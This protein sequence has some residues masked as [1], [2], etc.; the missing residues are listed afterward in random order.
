MS[1]KI[2]FSLSVISLAVLGFSVSSFADGQICINDHNNFYRLNYTT[3]PPGTVIS[4]SANNQELTANAGDTV[5]TWA[6]LAIG[7]IPGGMGQNQFLDI[8]ANGVQLKTLPQGQS[9][10]GSGPTPKP[11]APTAFSFIAGDSSVIPDPNH[12]GM[13]QATIAWGEWSKP[14]A[15][16]VEVYVDGALVQ[17]QTDINGG[18]ENKTTINN[19]APGTHKVDL[20]AIND[21]GST[22][23]NTTVQSSQPHTKTFHANPCLQVA[24]TVN[25]YEPVFKVTNVCNTDVG[26]DPESRFLFNS[27]KDGA[28]AKAFGQDTSF[29]YRSKIGD[30]YPSKMGLTM[31]D[32]TQ[33]GE[34]K[35]KNQEFAYMQ[36]DQANKILHANDSLSF[37]FWGFSKSKIAPAANLLDA[38]TGYDQLNNPDILSA[39][40]HNNGQPTKLTT[41]QTMQAYMETQTGLQIYTFAMPWNQD[42]LIAT[43]PLAEKGPYKAQPWDFKSKSGQWY[44]APAQ[45]VSTAE[46]VDVSYA[47]HDTSSSINVST[48]YT[49]ND[50]SDLSNVQ[51]G[52][53]MSAGGIGEQQTASHDL[54]LNEKFSLSNLLDNRNFKITS[55][56]GE[57][58]LYPRTGDHNFY[59][60]LAQATPAIKKGNEIDV[61]TGAGSSQNVN[62]NYTCQTHIA[63]KTTVNIRTPFGYKSKTPIQITIADQSHHTKPIVLNETPNSHETSATVY[64]RDRDTYS[65]TTADLDVK[66]LFNH[67]VVY[68]AI[69]QP[70]NYVASQGGA[71]NI[72]YKR[73]VPTFTPF[74]DITLGLGA[75][76]KKTALPK[77]L[78]TITAAFLVSNGGSC[79][80]AWGGYIGE[81]YNEGDY[82]KS[83]QSFGKKGGHLYIS[84]GGESGVPISQAC[85][86]AGDLASQYEGVYSFF[87]KD[88]I[89][90]LDF[91]IEGGAQQDQESLVKQGQALAIFQK[92]YPNAEIWLTLPTMQYGLTNAGLNVLQTIKDQGVKITGVNVMA[93]DYGQDNVEMGNAAIQA[94]QGLAKQ[95]K[96]KTLYP[97]KTSAEINA[98]IGVTPMIGK[99][100]NGNT[101]FTLADATKL[102]QFAKQ[103]GIARIAMWS[104][105]RDNYSPTDKGTSPYS[106]GVSE[107]DYGFSNNFLNALSEDQ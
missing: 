28:L 67:D 66:G 27:D 81:S 70:A 75:Y 36:F 92:Q 9:C 58:N 94:A 77:N 18:S 93:M 89:L 82:T 59:D 100:D 22:D 96:A 13:Y 68:R 78:N 72:S 73:V 29:G 8:T 40:V 10:T 79:K 5:D 38:V 90:G 101:P 84:F 102:G 45:P 42:K 54:T 83:L 31:A 35:T 2:V 33:P 74:D 104:L 25:G 86:S 37:Y 26:V 64:L 30:G 3:A 7:Q 34:V 6:G 52:S 65:I 21:A 76:N 15:T 23:N 20:K 71:V 43:A 91:D 69:V 17:T 55:S 98:M 87:A 105:N 19:L 56:T 46:T 44:S 63:D 12:K 48:T 51:L 47:P 49:S 107:K 39:T 57:F 41:S 80:P 53:L 60:C 62:I 97:N 99:N 24:Y 106:S 11:G 95:L 61:L 16:K 50:K 14:F 103:N 4:R 85:A 88:G 32:V 1:K